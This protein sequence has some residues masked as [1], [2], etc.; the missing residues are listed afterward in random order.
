MPNAVIEAM[1]LGKCCVVTAVNGSTEL[2]NSGD[3]DVLVKPGSAGALFEGL[4]QVAENATLRSRMG[5]AALT[6]VEATF[7]EA[8]RLARL[9]AFLSIHFEIKCNKTRI[10]YR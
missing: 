3:N 5:Q 8:R 7:S 1:G 2:I 9:Q 6:T 4:Q 10:T